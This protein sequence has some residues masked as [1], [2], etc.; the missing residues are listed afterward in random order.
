MQDNLKRVELDDLFG[1]TI[2]TDMYLQDDPKNN[3]HG[4]RKMQVENSCFNGQVWSSQ[5]PDLHILYFEWN[6]ENPFQLLVHNGKPLIKVQFELEGHS[7]FHNYHGE[8]IEIPAKHFQFIFMENTKGELTYTQSRKVLELYFKEEFLLA[9]LHSQG[10]DKDQLINHFKLSNCTLFRKANLIQ[11]QQEQI[12]QQLLTHTYR[13]DFAID[14]IKSK[15]IELLLSVFCGACNRLKFVE[16]PE[17]DLRILE[18][19]KS[20]LNINFAQDLHLAQIS[21]QF[22]I[23]EF[24]LKKAFKELYSETVFA[25]IRRKRMEYAQGLLLKTNLEIKEIAFLAGF[26]Y[27]HH[28]SKLYLEH[29]GIRPKQVRNATSSSSK[30]S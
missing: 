2:Q 5:Y 29:F 9:L 17:Q 27:P 28:F 15:A 23:N 14:F 21:R 7:H 25:Y 26:K 20:F 4:W 12:I 16:W 10:Y 1:K 8:P 3:L 22:G 6:L 19:I 24:K 11:P 30:N 18:E 13:S